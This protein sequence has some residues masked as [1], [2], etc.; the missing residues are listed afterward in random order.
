MSNPRKQRGTRWE[1]DVERFL[2][3]E[4]LQTYKPRQAGWTDLGD[5]HA[6]PFVVQAKD[7]KD[8]Q[9]AIR[10]GLDGAVRQTEAVNARRGNSVL[11]VPTAVVKRARRP[12]GDAYAVLRLRDLAHLTIA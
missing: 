4:G 2:D 3:G 8:W 7:W 1:T 5:I 6:W 9:S 11:W 12:V 10:E